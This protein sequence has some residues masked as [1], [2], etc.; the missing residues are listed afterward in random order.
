MMSTRIVNEAYCEFKE[1]EV[2]TSKT[3]EA[4]SMKL[5]QLQM[6]RYKS[7]KRIFMICFNCSL[8]LL[9]SETLLVS[10]LQGQETR[11]RRK[12]KELS[13]PAGTVTKC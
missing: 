10:V 7:L 4:D 8:L 11:K 13:G 9:R 6:S 3:A 1:S 12:G 5:K 2:L